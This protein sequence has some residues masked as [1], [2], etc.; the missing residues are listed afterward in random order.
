LTAAFRTMV[1]YEKERL[2]RKAPGELQKG[3]ESASPEYEKKILNGAVDQISWFDLEYLGERNPEVATQC[4]R[5][6]KRA[7]L[8]DL[9]SG[10][11]AARVMEGYFSNAWMR[12]QFLAIRGDLMSAWQPRDGMERQLIDAMAQAQTAM[13]FWQ[14]RLGLR[15]SLEPLQEK[16]DIE[17]RGGW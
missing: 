12:A 10:H 11:R 8:D 6:M 13:F 2:R 14:E 7:A 15:A 4:W 3:E 9:Q 5:K 16:L 1:E 17:K